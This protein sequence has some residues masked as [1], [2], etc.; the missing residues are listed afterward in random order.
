MISS[1]HKFVFLHIP[2]TGG[3][4]IQ[5]A[6]RKHTDDDLVILSPHQD[7]VERFEI[8]NPSHKKLKKHSNLQKY[9][10]A[11]GGELEDYYIFTT[12]RNPYDKLVS[13]Y[14]S[15]HRGNVEWNYEEF[16]KFARGVSSL[17]QY[18]TVRKNIFAKRRVRD[19][20]IN[21]FIRFDYLS[22]DLEE[23]CADLKI[24]GI[25]LAHRNKSVSRLP[26]AECFDEK[27]KNFVAEKHRFEIELGQYSF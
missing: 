9:Y 19:S 23:V 17:E 20:W 7:G 24:E 12:I 1:K 18:L 8:R 4:S 16:S 15:P 5:D 13:F 25:K 3:N 22:E 6:L 14:F 26:Y 21:K 2:K 11:L 27:L 10:R